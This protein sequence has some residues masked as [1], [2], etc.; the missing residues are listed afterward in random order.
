MVESTGLHD[1]R[2]RR[3]KVFFTYPIQENIIHACDE[4]PVE[5]EYWGVRRLE[6]VGCISFI[7]DGK[8]EAIR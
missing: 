5:Y 4:G 7:V 1:G 3:N 2:G 6:I 8:G